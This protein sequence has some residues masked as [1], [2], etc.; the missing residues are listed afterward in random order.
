MKKVLF[1]NCITLFF[2]LLPVQSQKSETLGNNLI[3]SKTLLLVEQNNNSDIIQDLEEELE[4]LKKDVVKEEPRK[5]K[6]LMIV[7]HPDDETIWGGGHL[8]ADDYYVVCITCDN[9]WYRDEEFKKVMK[10]TND[11]YVFLG[12]PDLTRGYIDDWSS[13]YEDIKEDLNGIINSRDWNTIV[14]HNPEGEYG[15][16]HHQMTNQIVTELANKDKLYYFGRYYTID[17]MP[18]MPSISEEL[19]NQ[20]MDKLISIY[21][22]QPLAMRRHHHMMP[23]ENFVTYQEW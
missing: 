5:E 19:Y 7:A 16:I 1:I 3:D 9:V 2:L 18:E 21:V 4:E 22:S 20:K 12:Y 8:L 23:Y 6:N 15:H 13:S 17:N 10:E 14:T 11:E